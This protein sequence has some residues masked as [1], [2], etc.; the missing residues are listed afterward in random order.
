[1]KATLS[2]RKLPRQITSRRM[3]PPLLITLAA[4]LAWSASGGAQDGSLSSAGRAQ[5]ILPNQF[6]PVYQPIAAAPDSPAPARIA[7]RISELGRAFGP[8]VS[9]SVRDIREGWS[10][11][12]NGDRLCP[13]QS[14]SKLWVALAVFDAIDRGALRPDDAMIVTRNDLTLFHQPIRALVG[15]NGYRATVSDLLEREMTQSDNTANDML[16]RR[17]GGPN[18]IRAMLTR[19]R[20]QNVRFGPGERL[21]Q[22]GIA[23]V[24]W[25]QAFASGNGFEQARASLPVEKRR[26]ALEAYAENPV[27]GAAPNAIT[28]ALAR[29][30]RG[31]LLTPTGTQNLLALMERSKTGR[32]RMKAA[33]EPDWLLAHK[34]GTGQELGGVV[35]GFNDVGLLT[36]P[37]GHIYAVAVMVARSSRPIG[38]RQAIIANVARAVIDDWKTN[39]RGGSSPRYRR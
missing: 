12:W 17:V 37:D 7:S 34:T 15:D 28:L 21:L 38:E 33:I 24:T 18:A 31:E 10:T 6:Q 35:A 32:A 30:V 16:L 19:L 26:A 39:S 22:S 23:G 2:R 4:T 13:Q 29:L 8:G 27:D 3:I 1:M 25:R 36:A 20:I 9:I 11:S 5:S 14:V